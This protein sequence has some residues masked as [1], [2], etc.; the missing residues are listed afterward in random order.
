MICKRIRMWRKAN[1]QE[2]NYFVTFTYDGKLH[3]EDSFKKSLRRCL[4]NFS[5]RNGWKY[6]GVW[7][8]SPEKH[9]LHFHGVFYIPEGT[10][11]K[12]IIE[13]ND[14]SLPLNL[15]QIILRVQYRAKKVFH[16]SNTISSHDHKF[17][18]FCLRGNHLFYA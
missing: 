11:P 5:N 12:M 4:W 15:R 9:R 3:T 13:K 17:R 6:I 2:F 1:L 16:M 14:Y 8:R 18:H 10:M 7:E